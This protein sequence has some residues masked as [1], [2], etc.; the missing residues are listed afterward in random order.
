MKGNAENDES[1]KRLL[2]LAYGLWSDR[3][4]LLARRE[5]YK[6][7]TYGDQWGDPVSDGEGNIV[8]EGELISRTG[9]QPLTNNLI[10]RLV[11]TVVGRFRHLASE[12][13][14]YGA[15]S[16]PG[17]AELDSRLLEEFL[18]SGQAIQRISADN[19]LCPGV[20]E[21]YNVNPRNFVVN[22]YQD[23]CGRDIEVVGMLHDM[24]RGEVMMRFGG[25]VGV[26]ALE[27]MYGRE[28]VMEATL[29][30]AAGFGEA[31]AGYDRVV[32]LWTREYVVAGD[33]ADH[34]LAGT[35]P[36]VMRWRCTWLSPTG[37]V[38][39]SHLSDRAD[40][41][42]PFAVKFYPLTDGEVHSFVE[43]VID[44]QRY[45]NR[46]VVLIDHMLAT[47][48]KG[49]L[50]FPVSQ[51]VEGFPWSEVTRRWA[52]T[53]GVIPI[54]GDGGTLPHQVVTGNGDG[55][56]HRLLELELK[57][58]EDVSGV[59]SAL[60]GQ[61]SSGIEGSALYE[62]QVNSATIALSD[63]FESFGSMLDRRDAMLG[64]VGKEAGHGQ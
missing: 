3:R 55:T 11:K 52:R 63:V 6:R 41:G 58:F 19:P 26:A 17:L 61:R 37:E 21:V 38:L 47:S 60:S 27:R 22:R 45:V 56:A 62:Q 7:Y 64:A 16:P 23:A 29:G 36:G 15:G 25:T 40:G 1:G 49:V 39:D 20:T 34:A 14:R 35:A 48:A 54:T 12:S 42:H 8:S 9:R 46:L 30:R 4:T 10:R 33:A 18:I 13:G 2:A 24:T 44:Q 59:S 51:K 43:D 5:R 31:P 57:L 28:G 50:L 53:D 32:E